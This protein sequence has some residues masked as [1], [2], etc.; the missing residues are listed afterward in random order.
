MHLGGSSY[1]GGKVGLRHQTGLVLLVVASKKNLE[2]TY[3]IQGVLDYWDLNYRDPR[4]TGIFFQDFFWIYIV[5]VSSITGKK[6][7]Q[8]RLP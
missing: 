7:K 1:L 4:N 5:K 6:F 3:H 8:I 2:Y